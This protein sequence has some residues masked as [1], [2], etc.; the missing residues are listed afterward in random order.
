MTGDAR[1]DTAEVIP[2]SVITGFLGSGKTTL[3]NRLLGHVDMAD[4]AVVVNEFGDVGLDHLLVREVSENLVLLNAGCICC[5]VRGDLVGALRDLFEKRAADAVPRFRRVVV[6]TTGLADPAPI[7]HTLMSDALIVSHYRLDG[8]ITTVDTVLGWG[9]LDEHPES[10]KQAAVADRI[11]LTKVDLVADESVASLCHRLRGLNPAADL[12]PADHG[13]VAPRLLLN[14]GLFDATGKTPDVEQWL[15]EEAYD[16]SDVHNHN[17][18]GYHGA[19]SVSR[20]RHDSHI[21]AFCMT[22]AQPIHWDGVVNWLDMLLSTRG[23]S[24]LRIKGILNVAGEDRPVAIHG[25]QHIFHPPA[26]LPAWPDG[27]RRS[28]IVFITQ[29]LGR[30][31][32]EDTFRAFNN[33]AATSESG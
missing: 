23:E 22:V 32:I 26:A 19:D 8:I 2:V 16:R 20:D 6:E 1:R 12:I 4:T 5:S 30:R 31:A 9:Q 10:V 11:V 24:V 17:D 28:R 14:T 27:E 29:G 18:H 15:R 21:T 13:D 7:I 25:V 3:L 33:D